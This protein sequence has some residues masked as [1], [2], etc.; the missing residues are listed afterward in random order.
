MAKRPLTKVVAFTSNTAHIVHTRHPHKFLYHPAALISP[1][2]SQVGEIPP[3]FWKLEDGKI[4]VMTRPEK[5]ERLRQLET[6]DEDN[7]LPK[8]PLTLKQK[9]HVTALALFTAA[10]GFL[11]FGAGLIAGIVGRSYFGK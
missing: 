10:P 7:K 3:K 2:L 1:D 11:L 9:A 5:V 6:E 8:A 4:A